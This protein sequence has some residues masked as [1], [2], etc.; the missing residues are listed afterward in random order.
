MA[1]VAAGPK[2]AILGS[3]A[4]CV[5]LRAAVDMTPQHHGL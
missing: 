1:M 5:L 4:V 3:A 2:I